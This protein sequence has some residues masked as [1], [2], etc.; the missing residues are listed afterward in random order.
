[1]GLPGQVHAEEFVHLVDLSDDRVLVA[2]GAFYFVRGAEDRRWRIADDEELWRLIGRRTCIG[3]RA[4]SFGPTTVEVLG[5]DGSMASPTGP[6]S[7]LDRSI[8]FDT[9]GTWS[10]CAWTRHWTARTARYTG[11]SR[12]RYIRTGCIP[13]SGGTLCAGASRS[14][15]TPCS[16]L[17]RHTSTTTRCGRRSFRSSTRP[18]YVWCWPAMSTTFRSTRS[19]TGRMSSP[20]P[21]ASS[22]R[23]SRNASRR[24]VRRPGLPRRTWCSSRWMVRG[25]AHPDLRTDRRRGPA[26]DDRAR[27]TQSGDRPTFCGAGCSMTWRPVRRRVRRPPSRDRRSTTRRGARRTAPRPALSRRVRTLG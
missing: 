15:I 2:W 14:R 6:R 11:S 3:S 20:A 7:T 4:E 13:R 10:S 9:A 25:A 23:T 21:E 16:A 1:M 24:P 22:A 12:R 18:V 8:G 27:P 26:P 5:L 19:M 17:A